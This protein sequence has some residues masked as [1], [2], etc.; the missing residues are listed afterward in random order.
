MTRRQLEQ[1][2]QEELRNYMAEMNISTL[3]EKS[4]PEPYDRSKRRKMTG[5]QIARRDKIGKAMLNKPKTVA[6]L[7]KKHGED[8][9]SYLWATASTIAL[10]SGE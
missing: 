7:K 8:W 3:H 1:I 6:R 10:R 9:E 4:V 5:A 2:I